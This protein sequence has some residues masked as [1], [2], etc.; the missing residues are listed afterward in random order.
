MLLFYSSK[1]EG[2]NYSSLCH[3][4]KKQ[5]CGVSHTQAL[6]YVFIGYGFHDSPKIILVCDCKC[7]IHA[8]LL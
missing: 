8:T 7:H 2:P 1:I 4:K 6:K 3:M 5:V